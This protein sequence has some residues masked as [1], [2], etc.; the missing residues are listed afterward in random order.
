MDIL[1]DMLTDL[2][3]YWAPVGPDDTGRK[4]YAAPVEVKCR[5]EEAGQEFMDP[6]GNRRV[7]TAVVYTDVD[8]EPLGV[9]WH[10]TKKV[11]DTAGSA[12]SEL[13]DEDDPFANAGAYEIQRFAKLPT[14][15]GD[16]FLR[17]SYL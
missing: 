8:T 11:G 12:I 2:A 15:D 16:E 5:W 9:L 4:T 3:V 13:T 10:S 6:A 14:F 17:T 1:E 7:S